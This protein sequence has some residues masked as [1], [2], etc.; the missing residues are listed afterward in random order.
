[1]TSAELIKDRVSLYSFSI[2]F[3][4][5]NFNQVICAYDA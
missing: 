4:G 5:I 3:S 2:V 1:M